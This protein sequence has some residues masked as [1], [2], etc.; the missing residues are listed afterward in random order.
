MQSNCLFFS[1]YAA[2]T[3]LPNWKQF[4]TTIVMNK[5]QY[6]ERGTEPLKLKHNTNGCNVTAK[7]RKHAALAKKFIVRFKGMIISVGFNM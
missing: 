4:T 5:N 7:R 3:G 6:L 2:E 1:S